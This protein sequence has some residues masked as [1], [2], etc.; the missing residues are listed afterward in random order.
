L[1]VA[2]IVLTHD[3]DAVSKTMAIRFKQTAFHSFNLV[4]NLSQGEVLKAKNKLYKAVRFMMSFDDYWCF[5]KIIKLEE[6]YNVRSQFNFYGGQGGWQRTLKQML[7]DPAYNVQQPK[8]NQQLQRLHNG[9][10]TIGLHQSYDA[11]D[12]ANS[13]W[14]EKERV[15]QAVDIPVKV[16]R[17]HW[18]RFGWQ[19]TWQAQQD[20]GFELDTTLGFN[21]RAG[22]RHSAALL[23]HPWNND[24]EMKLSV[25]PM[26]LM[27]SHLYDYQD[28]EEQE[29]QQQIDYWLDEIKAVGGTATI[30][31]HQ[32]VMSQDYGWESGYN[33]L[34]SKIKD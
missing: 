32:R 11:W 13:M 7:L 4:R 16:C 2:E 21:D 17:Q 15:E 26:V 28:L 29:R 34:L 30:I 25:L 24:S 1:P 6:K 22:F 10:W 20:A 19:K 23:H 31:W 5:D 27:D 18:L 14:Y 33:D 12:N 8:L 3:V 9:G